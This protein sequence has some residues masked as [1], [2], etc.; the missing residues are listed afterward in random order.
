MQ[1]DTLASALSQIL[2]SERIGRNSCTI[3]PSS[4]T[5]KKVLDILNE[6][7]YIGKYEESALKKGGVLNVSLIGKINNCGVVKTRFTV[8]KDGF[9]KFEKRFLLAKGFGI[10]IVST[11][12]GM[13]VHEDA[14]KKGIG[15]KLIAFCY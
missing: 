6:K 10:L 4:T 2:N 13:M 15:G 9:E 5:I 3:K 7:R 11:S 14:K 8:K 1:N 12:Q